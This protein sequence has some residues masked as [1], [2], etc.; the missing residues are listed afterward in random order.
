MEKMSKMIND[1]IFLVGLTIF[2]YLFFRFVQKKSGGLAVINPTLWGA[3]TI[4]LLIK[5]TGVQFSDYMNANR[6]IIF[7]LAP[8]TI[9][10]GFSMYQGWNLIKRYPIP[11]I[12]ATLISTVS[13]LIMAKVGIMLGGLNGLIAN[14]V[15][16]K[17]VTSPIG[18]LIVERIGGIGELA[19]FGIIW[20]GVIGNLFGPLLFKI[21]RVKTSLAQGY[22][23]GAVA[24]ILGLSRAS[25]MGIEQGAAASLAISFTGILTILMVE[26]FLR[27][28]IIQAL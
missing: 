1:P 21:F 23:L 10:L 20:A 12:I 8:M 24:H 3:I 13:A 17:S 4:L 16:P 5:Y 26:V 27:L 22:A 14:A 28:H 2:V 6:V 11:L 19:V 9:A 18:L 15:I 7:F 25:E